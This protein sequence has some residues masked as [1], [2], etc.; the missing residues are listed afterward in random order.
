MEVP[1]WLGPLKF[2]TLKLVHIEPLVIHQSQSG[3]PT[4]V[5]VYTGVSA[6]SLCFGKPWLPIFTY[7]YLQSEVCVFTSYRDIQE[8]LIFQSVRLFT[9]CLDKVVTF[10][11]L[12]CGTT[13]F[14]SFVNKLNQI[15]CFSFLTCL[16]CRW[17]FKWTLLTVDANSFGHKKRYRYIFACV[18]YKLE[19]RLCHYTLK[20]KTCHIRSSITPESH[21]YS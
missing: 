10:K 6:L 5:L 20:E 1:L 15:H 9:C 3:F 12:T 18:H 13:A 7:L 2:L 21:I 11:F 14:A 17:S 19:E 16:L 8:E 4:L